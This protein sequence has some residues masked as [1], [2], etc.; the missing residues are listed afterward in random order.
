[1]IALVDFERVV[2]E[3]AGLNANSIGSSTIE[4]GVRE[5][6][7]AIAARDLQEYWTQ[8]TE[9]DGE[10]QA[11]IEAIV[12]PETW[13]FR[14]AAAFTALQQFAQ[15]EWSPA[16]GDRVMQVLSL[17]CSTGEEPYSIAM[18][19]LDAG[20]A[21]S[22]FRVRAVDISQ[23]SLA[24]A[25]RGVYGQGAF[26][27]KD[28]DFRERHFTT[29]QHGQALSRRVRQQV[30]FQHGN[31]FAPGLF[32]AGEVFDVVFCRNLLIY[33]NQSTQERAVAC[34]T[35]F[36]APHGMLFV[37]S[38]E[39]GVLLNHP[40]LSAKL[41][42]A[43]AFRR[44]EPRPSPT[45]HATTLRRAVSVRPRVA[46]TPRTRTH[47]PPTGAVAPRSSA[48]P[49]SADTRQVDRIAQALKLANEGRFA[50]AAVYC[51]EQLR[52]GGPAPQAFHLLGLVRDATGDKAAAVECY[53]KALYLDPAHAEALI[54][55]ALLMEE[56]GRAAEARLLRD[57]FERLQPR[58]AP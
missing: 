10:R 1:V 50:Q 4:R 9:D 57:R 32:H 18:A 26:R 54:H 20:L 14:D 45:V 11:L 12:V 40:Y 19:L 42:R 25:R 47:V 28:L 53:R 43:Y 56:Q 8:L 46:P 37:G 29:T 22:R 41:P 49:R 6:Q 3:T 36:L 39:T 38:A 23:R 24:H 51:E 13:F 15:C 2:E 30:R 5:R 48:P 27:G 34:L 21:P 58:M 33:F 44:T 16:P 35:R 17:P 7:H 31:L 55:L 52:V